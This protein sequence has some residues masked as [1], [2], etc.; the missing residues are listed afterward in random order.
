MFTFDIIFLTKLFRSIQ[1]RKPI[2]QPKPVNMRNYLRLL[3]PAIML[4][5]LLFTACQS[6]VE[7]VAKE[8]SVTVR[9]T[10]D[11]ENLNFILTSDAKATE[12]FR[13]ISMPM[14]S[15]DPSTLGLSPTLLKKMPVATEITEGEYKGR[16]RYD[17]ELLEEAVWDNG[18]PITGEDLLFT[19]KTIN[20][21]NYASPHRGFTSFIKHVEIDAVNPKKISV[22][23]V[24]YL[25]A[26]PVISN[27]EPM[28]KYIYDPKG[29]LD[30]YT[31]AELKDKN[32]VEKMA[33]DT[34]L[35]AFADQFQSAYHLNNPAGISYSG[36]YKVEKWTNSQE[37]VLTKKKNWWGEKL[38]DKIPL[39]MAKPD[40]IIFKFV[41]DINAALSLAKN[42]KVDIISKIPWTEFSKLKEDKLISD[43]FN[44]ETPGTITYRYISLNT[45]NPRFEDKRVRKA[46]DHLFDRDQIY[47]TV[48]YGN[49]NPTIGPIHPSKPYYNTDL[50]VRSFDVEKA[51]TLLKA[52]GWEDTNGDGVVDKMIDGEKVE[53]EFELIY[54]NGYQDYVSL[55]NI[56]KD[57]AI[58]AG[59]KIMTKT[60]E[61]QAYF[62]TIRSRNFDAMIASA[63]WL[64]INK[65]I[66]A[67]FHTKGG[68]NFGSFSN[69]ELDELISTIRFSTDEKELSANYLKAQEIIHSEAPNIFINTAIDRII[70]NKK[71]GKTR[72]TPVK[73]HYYVNEFVENADV[74]IKN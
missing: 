17:F 1:S 4:F 51:K 27:F 50:Q 67:R 71:F 29:L 42:G 73:P 14:A 15:F 44:I 34:T 74:L 10:S 58:K 3:F 23:G 41:P 72:V 6:A 33:A 64:T 69:P 40:K 20:N 9:M 54:A 24:K 55:T 2:F 57:Q 59:V 53:M 65:D 16:I 26:G 43:Q 28:P 38:V 61:S 49:K 30:K 25:I 70:I 66:H 48:Y 21:P 52:A 22:T 13:L 8:T 36:P 46:L 45:A 5:S 31:L 62:K 39:L 37:I 7:E 12:I 60:I 35:K 68:Q 56:F 47:N 63:Q 18:S 19:L 32:N 11:P